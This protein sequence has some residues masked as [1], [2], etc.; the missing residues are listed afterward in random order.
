MDKYIDSLIKKDFK[1][2]DLGK[3][4]TV[5]NDLISKEIKDFRGNLIIKIDES[6]GLKNGGLIC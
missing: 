3:R 5:M 1:I 4:S 6:H 2:H